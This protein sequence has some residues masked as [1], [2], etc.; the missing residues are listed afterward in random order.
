VKIHDLWDSYGPKIVDKLKLAGAAKVWVDLKLHDIPATVGKRA[1]AVAD[2]GAD[3]IT[4]HIS[5]GVPMMKAA[6]ESGLEVYGIT[7]LTSLS[8]GQ[9]REIY[10]DEDVQRVALKFAGMAAKAGV[11]GIVCSPLEVARIA[12]FEDCH[13]LKLVVPGTRSAG[14]EANDQMRVDTPAAA[15]AAGAHHLVIGRQITQAADPVAAYEALMAEIQPA[16]ALRQDLQV[17]A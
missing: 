4:V 16:L 2:A 6:V 5:G 14:Q 13:A 11:R 1:K 10:R 3:I 7:V 12:G 8:P 15:I 9:V 17:Q